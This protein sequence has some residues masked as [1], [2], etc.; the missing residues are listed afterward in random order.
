MNL[1]DSTHDILNNYKNISNKKKKSYRK[2]DNESNDESISIYSET[3]DKMLDDDEFRKKVNGI[4][5]DTPEDISD[6][7]KSLDDIVD[8][9]LNN[10]YE[11][12]EN[13]NL[14][15]TKEFDLLIE[16]S[17]NKVNKQGNDKN[18]N[19]IKDL[20]S[21]DEN[22]L[23]NASNLM[24]DSNHTNSLDLIEKKLDHFLKKKSNAL[25]VNNNI[26]NKIDPNDYLD[27]KTEFIIKETHKV[28]SKLPNSIL[29]NKQSEKY[30]KVLNSL[31]NQLIK[32][33][34]TYKE[35]NKV[36]KHQNEKI[37]NKLH[38][39]NNFDS[40]F[41]SE[42]SILKKE[43]EMIQKK[44]FDLNSL[45][46]KNQD[47]EKEITLLKKNNENLQKEL[48]MLKK[49]H[50]MAQPFDSQLLKEN[51]LL[52]SK[53]IKYKDLYVSLCN[54]KKNQS[55][56]I[57]NLDENKN[58]SLTNSV[59]INCEEKISSI[60]NDKQKLNNN[61][62]LNSNN[63]VDHPDSFNDEK[64]K[65]IFNYFTKF[66]DYCNSVGSINFLDDKVNNN[67]QS[68]FS[69]SDHLNKNTNLNQNLTNSPIFETDDLNLSLKK[70]KNNLNTVRFNEDL[71][72]RSDNNNERRKKKLNGINAQNL[73]HNQKNNKLNKK[74][75]LKT[76]SNIET[77][78]NHFK[79]NN[80]LK[81]QASQLISN[82][83]SSVDIDNN[84]Y[85]KIAKL[86]LENT[87]TDLNV[88]DKTILNEIKTQDSQS[89]EKKKILK[90]TASP[91]PTEY[92]DST[93]SLI[94]KKNDDD[95]IFIK[96]YLCC[97]NTSEVSN[98]INKHGKLLCKNSNTEKCNPLEN[99][100]VLHSNQIKQNSQLDCTC[101]N[102]EKKMR[103]LANDSNTLDLMGE[104]TWSI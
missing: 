81:T 88:K 95:K 89:S 51:N 53:L 42:N 30:S 57:K 67:H 68:N 44:K 87:A 77:N 62:V 72:N 74:N 61:D 49:E 48:S 60:S 56:Q 71:S 59:N 76:I 39:Q 93:H 6:F 102:F 27:E 52:R 20:D 38:I 25:K 55:S 41:K 40:K 9:N 63:E 3:S 34:D 11:N 35:K 75:D 10:I 5:I 18:S 36:L 29:G 69:Q 84:L 91:E 97:S 64:I 104:Y 23:M 13:S 37:Q 50:V 100:S 86:I 65:N 47:L 1:L 96:C 2:N 21:D 46:C 103:T 80:I 31:I 54:E 33:L 98:A 14:N 85:L 7:Y 94:A 92:Q 22:F 73:D 12:T 101:G 83:I 90:N 17:K 82:L 70:N 24:L 43:I 99:N 16:K 66:L 15:K 8:T 28:I 19:E 26:L 78:N 58:K 45:N 32:S 79:K 4:E